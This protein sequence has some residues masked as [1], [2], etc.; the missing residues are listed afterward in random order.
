MRDQ[1]NTKRSILNRPS[2]IN[3]TL[4][5]VL[6]RATKLTRSRNKAFVATNMARLRDDGTRGATV[7]RCL[8]KGGQE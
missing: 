5:G 8:D 7:E 4:Y 1:P 6:Q 3:L 2:R